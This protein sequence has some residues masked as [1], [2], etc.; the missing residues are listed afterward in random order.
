MLL[1]MS[2]ILIR[3]FYTHLFIQ[4]LNQYDTDIHISHIYEY[5]LS[6]RQNIK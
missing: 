4:I 6:L 3:I 1:F 2:L 5:L